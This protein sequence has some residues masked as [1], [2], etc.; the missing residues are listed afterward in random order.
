MGLTPRAMC[1]IFSDAHL[2]ANAMP[3]LDFK[4]K[5][6]IYAHHLT[7]PY[8]PLLSDNIRS[9]LEQMG[10]GNPNLVMSGRRLTATL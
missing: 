5:S 2:L 6:H 7:V 8:R 9:K 3:T 10:G 4:G 1:A